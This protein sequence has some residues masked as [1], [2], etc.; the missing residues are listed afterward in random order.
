LSSVRAVGPDLA[1]AIV[2]ERDDAGPYTS[3]EELKRRV[4]ARA[5]RLGTTLELKLDAL[6][7]L[8]TAGAFG[9]FAGDR[10]DTAR[11]LDRRRALWGAGAV[12]QTGVDRLP[13]IVTGTH[14]PT[15]PGMSPTEE[16]IADLWATGVAPEGHPTRFVRAELEERGV[17]PASGLAQ[18][19]HGARVAVAG[20]VTHRQRPATAGGTTFVNLEDETGLINVICSK[21]CWA[22]YRVVARSSPALL[23]RGRLEKVEGVINIVADKIEPLPI[24][25]ETKARDFR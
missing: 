3:M 23:I 2:A 16:A 8:A 25:V 7:A 12:A 4:A 21:G 20:V 14:A 22:R 18:V 1:E 24:G 5:R 6:E 15:L 13:G 19:D 11:P 17:I 9:C 10:S